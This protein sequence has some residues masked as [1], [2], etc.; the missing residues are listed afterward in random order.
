WISKGDWRLFFLHRDRVEKV[1]ADDI[2]R[3]AQKYLQRNNRTVGVFIPTDKAERVAVPE[4]P[5]LAG[6]VDNYKSSRTIVPGEAFHPTP[7]N[8]EKRIV[9]P[10]K[11]P[12]VEPKLAILPKK[13][14]GETVTLQLTLRYGNEKSLTG[15]T[16]AAQFLG[17]LMQYGTAKHDRLELQD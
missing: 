10:V 3:V 13:S 12:K 14:R 17:P 5:A 7:E 2:S 11:D 15:Q 6:L 8:L 16:T 9:R 1:T 4:T